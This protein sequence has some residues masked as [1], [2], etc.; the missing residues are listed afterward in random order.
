M[1][2]AAARGLFNKL[3]KKQAQEDGQG[4]VGITKDLRTIVEGL[5]LIGEN[6]DKIPES[7]LATLE[8]TLEG[9]AGFVS[10]LAYEVVDLINES[11]LAE[12]LEESL[13]ESVEE[14]KS[15]ED[16]ADF[17]EREI[18]WEDEPEEPLYEEDE[19]DEED[20]TGGDMWE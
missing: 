1:R 8:E 10:D 4:I 12:E 2:T 5:E 17:M 18:D 9:A 15:K 3:Y 13:E 19:K 6:F 7:V 16:I 20:Y 11:G 14:E